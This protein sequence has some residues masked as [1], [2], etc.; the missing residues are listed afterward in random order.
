MTGKNIAAHIVTMTVGASL[1]A[2][3][4]RLDPGSTLFYVLTICLALV[5]FLGSTIAEMGRRVFKLNARVLALH[6][7]VGFGLALVFVIG[8][9]ALTQIPE[10]RDPVRQLL[11]NA[12]GDALALVA[13]ITAVAGAGEELYFRGAFFQ[14]FRGRR[15]IWL[16][17]LA[18]T[19]VTAATGIVL[20]TVA[21]ATLGAICA[22][23]RAHFDNLLGCILLHLSWSLSMLFV[24]PVILH[25]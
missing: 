21:A 24:L 10:L 14:E 2:V 18:Y 6:L 7:L 1:L 23:M 5:W 17:T 9:F 22:S 3:S 12:N 19:A 11:R 4:M 8:A 15:A 20:L 13:V 16:S 25:V